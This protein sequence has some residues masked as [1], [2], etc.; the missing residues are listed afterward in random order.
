MHTHTQIAIH[1]KLLD[2]QHE[3]VFIVLIE[4]LYLTL[5]HVSN[6]LIQSDFLCF[7]CRFCNNNPYSI[8]HIS[9]QTEYCV[10]VYVAKHELFEKLRAQ[11]KELK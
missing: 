1:K 4:F 6:Y 2:L 9:I 7:H 5:Y 3:K 8:Y 10:S 11:G